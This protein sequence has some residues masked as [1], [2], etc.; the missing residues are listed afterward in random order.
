MRKPTLHDVARAAGVSYATADRVLNARGNVAAKSEERVRE[1]IRALGYTR[2]LHA[3]NL[4][5]GRLYNFRFILPRGDHSFFHRLRRCVED[6]AVR[7]RIDRVAITIDDVPAFDPQALAESLGRIE[8]GS[9][10]CVAL[11]ATDGAIVD[12][13]LERLK[14]AGVFVIT[15]VSDAAGSARHAYVG[16]DNVRAGRTAG[17]LMLLGHS[18]RAGGVL[19]ILG[20][21]GAR[22]H[23]D[24]LRGFGDVLAEAGGQV[25]LVRVAEGGDDPDT[26]YAIAAD[27]LRDAALTGIYSIGAGN[28]GLFDALRERADAR[29]LA[30]VHELVPHSR[31]A[32]EDGLIDAVI[33]QMP[34]EEV[35][36]ALD[37][38]R[39]LSDAHP[40][41]PGLGEIAPAVFL[42]DNLSALPP[43]APVPGSLHP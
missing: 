2:D 19:A 12:A 27:A 36:A 28:R 9:C 14:S 42:R 15:L 41:P 26:I 24:R 6:E 17:R 5:R 13:E 18:G 4:S 43:A 39:A 10:D 23:R 21:Y 16:L 38:M 7:R 1:A 22:D 30:I 29:P 40:L 8:P 32:L 37:A 25:R 11:I 20:A 3:A 31:A 35:A 34:A 33:D